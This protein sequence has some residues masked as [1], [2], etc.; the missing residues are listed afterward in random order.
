MI[1]W[2]W[3]PEHVNSESL[4]ASPPLPFFTPFSLALATKLNPA[5]FS[6][7][8]PIPIS[9]QSVQCTVRLCFQT[10]LKFMRETRGIVKRADSPWAKRGWRILN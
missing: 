6:V 4:D 9:P 8:G 2:S 5:Y 1:R 3:R 7:W 10:G